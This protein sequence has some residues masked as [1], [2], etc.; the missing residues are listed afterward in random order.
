MA[1]WLIEKIKPKDN[2][3][4]PLVDA[5]DVEMPDGTRLSDAVL[6][7]GDTKSPVS[8]DLTQY[9]SNGVIVEHYADGSTLTNTVEFNADGKPIKVTSGDNE[10]TLEW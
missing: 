2:K 5:V 8:I 6:G 4:F 7:G 1:T 9:S 3:N 10:V